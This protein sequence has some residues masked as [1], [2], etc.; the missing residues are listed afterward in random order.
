MKQDKTLIG[1]LVH[2][3]IGHKF[4][5]PYQAIV[6]VNCVVSLYNKRIELHSYKSNCRFPLFMAP[7]SASKQ[8]NFYLWQRANAAAVSHYKNKTEIDTCHAKRMKWS[9]IF[10]D[11][12]WAEWVLHTRMK[13]PI[14]K[15]SSRT[16]NPSLHCGV[17]ERLR[18]MLQCIFF[19]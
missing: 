5:V 4:N 17:N 6:T 14:L 16:Q 3:L 19:Y 15:H 2:H 9:F 13:K 11:F 12:S 8:Q 1:W 7:L 18:D 10:L